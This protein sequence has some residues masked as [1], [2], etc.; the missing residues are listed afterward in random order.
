MRAMTQ[1]LHELFEHKCWASGRVLAAADALPN[2]EWQVPGDGVRSTLTH[3]LL[4]DIGWRQGLQGVPK[5]HRERVAAEDF[6]SPASMAARWEPEEQT[7]RAWLAALTDEELR[8]SPDEG[9]VPLEGYLLHVFQHAAQH[10]AEAAL[11]LTQ[12][13]HSP[14]D[15]DYLDYLDAKRSETAEESR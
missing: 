3:M 7:W 10:R 13:G 1:M 8:R 11:L 14:G 12:A 4:N 5:E 6:G 15:I 2:D 9:D